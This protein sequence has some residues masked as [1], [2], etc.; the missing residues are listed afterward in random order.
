MSIAGL[1]KGVETRLRA[2][3][4][5][6][7]Q[8]TE[9]VGR[10][11]GVQPDG[12]P[13]AGAGQW[14]YAV[15]FAGARTADPNSLSADWAYSATVSITKRM[16]EAPRDRRAARMMLEHELLD[17]AVYVAAVLHQNDIARIAMNALIVGTAEYADLH[18]GTET[19][20]GFTT[21]LKL[22]S[23]GNVTRAPANWVY[24]EEKTEAYYIDVKFGDAQRIQVLPAAR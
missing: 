10:V 13:P 1:L 6:N 8:P 5:L 4:V 19:V 18:G 22:L 14:Y 3:D 2:A 9:A 17:Q 11:C 21:P 16:G 12:S 7:D 15:W 20:N 23:V 24:S